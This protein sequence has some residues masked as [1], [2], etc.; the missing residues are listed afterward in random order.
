MRW[1]YLGLLALAPLAGCVT[2]TAQPY[3]DCK[4]PQYQQFVGRPLSEFRAAGVMGTVRYLPPNGIMTMDHLPW[5]INVAHDN[6]NT[7]TRIYCG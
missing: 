5:R 4:A 7:I 2:T 1:R 6:R 3:G